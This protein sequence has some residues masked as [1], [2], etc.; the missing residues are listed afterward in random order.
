[1]AV[2]PTDAPAHGG[3]DA[4]AARARARLTGRRDRSMLNLAQIA[5]RVPEA[6]RQAYLEGAASV[7]GRGRLVES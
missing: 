2:T 5:E 7:L 4:G 1:M 3:H 6:Y